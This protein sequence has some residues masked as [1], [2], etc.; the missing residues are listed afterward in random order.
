MIPYS[1]VFSLVCFNKS[2][3]EHIET[4]N[5]LTKNIWVRRAVVKELKNQIC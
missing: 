3:R 2:N 4:A 1:S 5:K